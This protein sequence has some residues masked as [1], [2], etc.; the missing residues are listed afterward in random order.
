MILNFIGDPLGFLHPTPDPRPLTPD[1]RY[2]Q[3]L[4]LEHFFIEIM[5]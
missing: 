5:T 3:Q 4:L 2:H 1:I